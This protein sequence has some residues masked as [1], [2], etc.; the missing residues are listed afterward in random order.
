[1]FD[2]N[3]MPNLRGL[4]NEIAISDLGDKI[5]LLSLKYHL[6]INTEVINSL[7]DRTDLEPFEE[8][9]LSNA[10]DLEHNLTTLIEFYGGSL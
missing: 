10:R 5:V 7:S 3:N 6:D 1:M 2:L 4:V 9:D 8:E